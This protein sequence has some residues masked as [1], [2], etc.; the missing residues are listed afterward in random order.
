[1]DYVK[2]VARWPNA[3]SRE[4][5]QDISNPYRE[6]H[7]NVG[8]RC[9]CGEEKNIDHFHGEGAKDHASLKE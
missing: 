2:P 3:T 4:P 7:A 1:M 9:W 5:R 6:S 8:V